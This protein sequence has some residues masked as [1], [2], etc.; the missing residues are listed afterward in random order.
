MVRGLGNDSI[1]IGYQSRYHLLHNN[2]VQ[3]LSEELH[4]FNKNE[5]LNEYFYK[6]GGFLDAKSNLK[7][8]RRD[9]YPWLWC[10]SNE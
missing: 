5:W 9:A 3:F 6:T 4:S 2:K 10:V 1:G 7:Q 8:W